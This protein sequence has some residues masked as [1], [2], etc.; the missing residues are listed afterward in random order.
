MPVEPGAFPRAGDTSARE[1]SSPGLK[2]AAPLGDHA[3]RSAEAPRQ[4]AEL[5]VLRYLRRTR[6]ARVGESADDRGRLS[7]AIYVRKAEHVLLFRA[8]N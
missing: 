3:S 6:T 2:P 7:Q 8:S 5:A 1:A 4:L